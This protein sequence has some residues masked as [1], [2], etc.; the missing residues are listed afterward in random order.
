MDLEKVSDDLVKMLQRF[1]WCRMYSVVDRL[2]NA[3][4]KEVIAQT[5]YE[6]LRISRSARDAGRS[7]CED[8][9]RV[10]P[11]VASEESIKAVL[12]LLDKDLQAGLEFV[13][14]MAILALTGYAKKEVGE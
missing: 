3:T 1:V 8:S 4:S 6:A 10:G 9:R 11:Y 13:R 7:L 2:A 5:L 14:K 12:E